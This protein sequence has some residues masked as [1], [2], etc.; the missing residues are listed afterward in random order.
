MKRFFFL[1]LFVATISCTKETTKIVPNE[2][3]KSDRL[4]FRDFKEYLSTTSMLS[5][6]SSTTDLQLWA[7]ERGHSTL[8]SD[9]SSTLANYP[10]ALR[11]ILNKDSEF[12]MGDSIVWFNKGNFYTYSRESTNTKDL[13]SNPNLYKIS[14]SVT[15]SILNS[16]S[17][18]TTTILSN[19]VH[20][21]F[22]YQ[23]TQHAYQPCG[24]SITY[25]DGNRKFIS[26]LADVTTN[27]GT[28][29]G[30]ILYLRIK[31]EW[32][33]SS[34]KEASEQ[35]DI[36]Y[37][38]DGTIQYWV[39]QNYTNLLPLHTSGVFSCATGNPYSGNLWIPE[40]DQYGASLWGVPHWVVNLSGTVT[41]H[42]LGD[43]NSPYST[44]I[45]W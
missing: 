10:P 31:L 37:N 34:W 5:R 43:T 32:K 15:T 38:F 40:Q 45:Y 27:Y 3:A 11:T 21:E 6:I 16:S 9:T 35:R 2:A 14:G 7:Q 44:Y 13:K 1:F 20:A 41:Q 39:G 8:L 4:I 17:A 42:V 12:Q 23:F 19:S 36:T 26:E 18:R 30:N 22:Q 29:Y 28:S 24:G 25:A 33:G